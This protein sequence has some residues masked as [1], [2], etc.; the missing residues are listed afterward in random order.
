VTLTNLPA[1]YDLALYKDISQIY[2]ELTSTQDL[3]QLSAEFAPDTFSPD[4]FSPDTFSPDTFSP[5][6]FSPDT[7]SPDTFSPDTFSPDTFSPDT[8][9]PDTFSPDTFSPDTFSPDTFS[10]D[11][12]S[13]DTFSPDTFSPDTF[14]PDTF[15]PDLFSSAQTRSLI[16]V[17]AH[18]GTMGEGIIINTWTKSEYFYVR[19]RGRNGVYDANAPFRLQ[20]S[21]LSGSC[22]LVNPSQI[23]TIPS[24]PQSGNYQTLILTN[25]SQTEGTTAEKASMGTKLAALASRTTGWV[26]DVGGS[27][28]QVAAFAA[29][30][31]AYPACVYAMNLQASSIKKI[32]DGFRALHPELRYIV[33]VGNDHAIPFFR[34]TDSAL[35]ASEIEYSPPVLDDTTSQ[36]SLKSGYTLSQ[37]A[38]GA[39][40][41][42]S[43]KAS[44]IPV[45]DLP[46]GRLVE[47]A[48]DINHMLDA[49]LGTTNGVVVPAN[50]LVTGYDF[51][52]DVADAVK[53]ELSGSLTTASLISPKTD[54]PAESWTADQLRQSFLGSRHDINFLAG[55]FSANSALAA[56]YQTRMTSV[57]VLNSS[58]NLVNSLVY[59]AGCHSGYNIVNAD[60]VPG[61]TQEP[62]WA[63]VFAA[64]G[65]TFIGGTGY[66]Y[67]D[68]DFIEYSERLYLE[69]TQQ[70]R[71]GSGPVAVGEALVQAKQAYLAATPVM[72]GIHE[73][74]V[75]EATLF[76]LPMLQFNL[77]GRIP[78]PVDNPV[79]AGISAFTE[80]PGLTLSLEFADLHVTPAFTSHTITLDQ[81]MP[82]GTILNVD[83]FYLE[84][85]DGVV[86]NP[87]EPVLPLDQLNVSSPKTGFVLRG[88]GWRGGTFTDL[89]DILPLTGAA[90]EDLRAPHSA[91]FTDIFF[92]VRPWNVN[93]FDALGSSGGTTDLVLMPAQYISANPGSQTGIL[94]CFD[95]MDFRLYYSNNISTYGP[96]TPALSAQPDISHIGSTINP[97]GTVSFEVTVTGDPAAG[98]QEVWLVYTFDNG[99]TAGAWLP[100]ELQQ[101]TN[102]SRL[103]K[104]TLALG[105]HNAGDLRFIVQAANGVGLVTMMTNQGQYYQAGVDPAAVPQDLSNVGLTL[106]SPAVAG[107]YG[108]QQSFT[109]LAKN[110]AGNP[111]GGL[112]ISFS[113]GGMGRL[114]L[115]DNQGKATVNFYL[116]A[117]PSDYLVDAAFAGNNTYA[118]ADIN[119]PFEIT[120][121]SSIVVLDPAAQHILTGH[122]IPFTATV[123]SAGLP[124]AGKPVALTL[125]LGGVRK[126]TGLSVTDFEGIAR[127]Q[128]P[129]Q[130]PG[131]YVVKAWFGLPVLPASSKLDLSSPFYTG[132]SAEGL[133]TVMYPSLEIQYSGETYLPAG[134][135][136]GI[137]KAQLSGPSLCLNDQTVT[138]KRDVNGDGTYET[139]VSTQKTDPSGLASTSLGGLVDGGIYEVE[140][141]TP[142]GYCNAAVNTE[143]LM[144]AGSGDSSNGGG[145]YNLTGAGRINLGYTLQVKTTKTGTTVTGQILWHLQG[146]T[147]LKG[148]ITAYNKA[149]PSGT[150]APSGT[151]CA[152][153]TGTG[154]LYAWNS[155]TNSWILTTSNVGFQVT[156]ADGGSGTSCTKKRCSTILNPDFFRMNLP[157]VDVIGESM[158]LTQLKGGNI[159]VK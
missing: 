3:T 63:Q 108:S 152:Y 75:L 70:L 29:Q 68:T 144:V 101:D 37:D 17:S 147:R 62:D 151:T 129:S 44:I 139:L 4:T 76:G 66:Q 118:P 100:L 43:Y 134:T 6:T 52:A 31:Q 55:H 58:T 16:A 9:S 90:T 61:V 123:T 127:W 154:D 13:P 138:F 113:L 81:T 94:R 158:Y 45:P 96:N 48:S 128:V 114:A 122:N 126:Y 111:L 102:D 41:E 103:W 148:N 38:Y 72:R 95:S 79:V 104:G 53:T 50:A 86:V 143:T 137:L 98:I 145:F 64:K 112:P 91:F 10:P 116:A 51:L 39:S 65:A 46:V 69:F 27:G 155:T 83:A 78:A 136:S 40:R 19:V 2:S 156:V 109:A 142:E 12:F 84:G 80:D 49:Y 32:V 74:T 54:A 87:S 35:L 7:F 34:Y 23:G 107:M 117:M 131:V 119:S 105:S 60:D 149:C 26:L 92:P 82:D 73:K 150:T 120:P 130:I 115:T 21:M 132:S 153:L 1:N 89:A 99:L 146:K 71:Y 77:P 56:D 25:L 30:A 59:S 33:L 97:D 57:E 125:D 124:L 36:A 85:P 47:T 8:F 14:S 106:E 24:L 15:S 42:V 18:D 5:D 93:Y 121:G 20:V 28:T 88:V 140:F 110:S 67:G 157:S 22:G 133:L 159:V 11:T 135:K 141:S